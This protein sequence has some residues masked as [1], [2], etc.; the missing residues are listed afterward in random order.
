MN[1]IVT[2]LFNPFVR[3]AGLCSLSLGLGI[4]LATGW[5]GSW[6]GAHFDG[7]L[8]THLGGQV[9]LW[10]FMAEG[11][12]DWLSLALVLLGAGRMISHTAFRAIDLIGTQALARWPMILVTFATLAPGFRRYSNELV[13]SLKSL[14]EDPPRFTL[15]PGGIDAV[16]FVFVTVVMLICAVWMVALMWK[17]FAHCCNV[18]GGR[19]VGAFVVSILV[20]EVISKILIGQMFRLA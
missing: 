10:M 1:S 20:A 3:V 8:D 2:P 19:A 17:S 14:A 7:V 13:Q 15:P 18:R 16:T 9:P 12:I 4:I 5:T 6:S 11:V